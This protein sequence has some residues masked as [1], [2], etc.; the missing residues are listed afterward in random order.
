MVNVALSIPDIPPDTGQMVNKHC[1]EA[2]LKETKGGRQQD[3]KSLW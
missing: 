3:P 1:R 2:K